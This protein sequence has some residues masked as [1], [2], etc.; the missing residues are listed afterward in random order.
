MIILME[1]SIVNFLTEIKNA[2]KHLK[3]GYIINSII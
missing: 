1:N 3:I 2:N